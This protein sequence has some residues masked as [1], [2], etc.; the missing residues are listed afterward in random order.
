MTALYFNIRTTLLIG[1]F[2]LLSSYR[3]GLKIEQMDN[4]PGLVPA[5]EQV[6]ALYCN[7]R[8]TLL[9]GTVSLLSSY[10]LGLK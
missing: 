2:I 7:I 8:T 6:T 4:K 10:R 9:M 5:L 3:L 1:T